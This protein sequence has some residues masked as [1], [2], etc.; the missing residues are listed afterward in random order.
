ML[1]D[2]INTLIILNVIYMNY[3]ITIDDAKSC[4][5]AGVALLDV[6][7]KDEY[8]SGHIKGSKNMDVQKDSFKDSLE[9]L[10]KSKNYIVY[11]G[12]GTR[13]INAVKIMKENGFNDAHSMS[14][15]IRE[16]KDRGF[17]VVK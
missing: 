5:D 4:I 8:E 2:I 1:F 6:R 15:G 16:W 17:E 10:D 11:C 9:N 7:T 13:S 12:G 3:E 14:G